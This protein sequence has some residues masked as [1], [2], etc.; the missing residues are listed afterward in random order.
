M[1]A[2]TGST[3]TGSNGTSRL[4]GSD[5][6]RLF[7]AGT[8]L[9]LVSAF[10]VNASAQSLTDSRGGGG[11]GGGGNGGAVGQAGDDGADYGGQGGA[12]GDAGSDDGEDGS[13]GGAGVDGG[14]G[15]GGG[16][17]AIGLASLGGGIVGT[18]SGGDGGDGGDGS[19]SGQAGVDGNSSGGGGGGAGG[20]AISVGSDIVVSDGTTL[21]GG[22]GGNGGDSGDIPP[23]GNGGDGGSGIFAEGTGE[24]IAITVQSGASVGG[25]DAG[26]PGASN[27]G[28]TQRGGRG[29]HGIAGGSLDI[30][31]E[32]FGAGGVVRGGDGA[33]GSTGFFTEGRAGAGSDGGDGVVLARGD[34]RSYLSNNGVIEG[35]SGGAGGQ[36]SSGGPGGGN[37]GSSG[38][39]GGDGGAGVSA[40]DAGIV[41]TGEI[42]GGARGAAG[43]GNDGRPGSGGVG[44]VGEDLAVINAGLI[45]GANGANAIAFTGGANSLELF[46][47]Y[48]FGGNVVVG[49]GAT[50]TMTLGGVENGTLN[51]SGI[52]DEAAGVDGFFVGF[53]A[54]E[55]TGASVWTLSGTGNQDWVISDG[56]LVGNTD[57]FGGD[58][59]LSDP[60][61]EP[62]VVFEQAGV[63]TYAGSLSGDG[64]LV[65]RG[66]GAVQLTGDS[67]EFGGMTEV[68]GSTLIVEGALG[69]SAEIGSD[70]VL[71][72][73]GTIGS[74]TGSQVQMGDGSTMAPGNSIGTL[75]VD[76]DLA[77]GSGSLFKVEVAPGGTDSDLVEVTGRAT[78]DG[79]SVAHVGVT[80]T[81][82]PTQSYTILSADEGVHGTFDPDAVTSEFEFLDPSLAYGEN[83]I[84]LTLRRNDIDFG[85]IG[86]TPNQTATGDSI[87]ALGFGDD[88]YD[89]VVQLDAGRAL[90]AFDQLSGEIH[91]SMLT[92]LI[93]DSRHIRNAANDR[94]RAA[95]DAVGAART[96]ILAYGPEGPVLAPA[97]SDHGMAAWG[98]A[99]GSWSQTG[100][101]GNAARLDRDTGGGVFGADGLLAGWRLGLLAGYSQARYLADE[102]GSSGASDTYHLGAYGGTQW[103]PLA[104]RTGLAYS[105][106]DIETERT[107]AFTGIGD[108]LSAG[109]G[110]RTVQA[111]GELG[112]VIETDL[113][114][115]EPFVRLAH[116]S[117]ATDAFAENGGVAALGGSGSQTDTTFTTLGVRGEADFDLGEIDARLTG[118]AGWRHAFG[119]TTPTSDH[120]FAGLEAF[121]IAGAPIAR[122]SAVLEAGLELDF[123]PDASLGVSYQGQLAPDAQDH[124]F[125]ANLAI[126]F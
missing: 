13:D 49:E 112:H 61:Q 67:A 26:G 123:T 74:G 23:G 95:F 78:I 77:F 25:G 5:L 19:G 116:V 31:I 65:F 10:P 40:A 103:G 72:G 4:G 99:F 124:G 113:A 100:S 88:L 104:L 63:G 1:R 102:R 89:A 38:G 29:G 101:D 44:V 45:A 108:Q 42:R 46:A 92:G 52:V 80:G 86:E 122:D 94:I 87:D 111:F 39:I 73:T 126:K 20:H 121:T 93:Q 57:S 84:T 37:G 114:R 110:A 50:G 119:D 125:K 70:G 56:T 47:R 66:G 115:F 34:N 33:N 41:N 17:G 91:A 120:G 30:T 6:R 105:W 83:D 16:G 97:A 2:R 21:S 43:G 28:N 62:S 8:A 79:G 98:Y 68:T 81:Y 22:N 54:F 51:V 58:L 15:G 18:I 60:Q 53:D 85:S 118:M 71:A 48:E 76:G 36:G 117:V 109:Y 14:A 69:G 12:G 107:V 27:F 24:T 75:T 90:D 59:T 96:P 32:G 64:T 106:S 35:G 55:K 7:L 3:G 82:D 11:N 9:V